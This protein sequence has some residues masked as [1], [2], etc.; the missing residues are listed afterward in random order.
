MRNKALSLD[1][2]PR[3]AE[4]LEGARARPPEDVGGPCSYGDFLEAIRDPVH[5]VQESNLRWAGGHFDPEWF[6]LDLINKDLQNT[7]R[8]N[9]RRRLH[10][11]KPKT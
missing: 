4:C 1:P 8:A 6:D 9:V 3:H 11:P 5:E 7:F 2:V 10:Q